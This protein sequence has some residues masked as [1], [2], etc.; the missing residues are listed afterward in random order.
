[1][2]GVVLQLEQDFAD[3]PVGVADPKV[4]QTDDE[5]LGV[6]RVVFDDVITDH[7]CRVLIDLA[8]VSHYI[9]RCTVM[10]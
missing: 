8:Q 5:L 2:Y 3:Y 7:Q 6:N 4:V 10:V 9:D 1:M